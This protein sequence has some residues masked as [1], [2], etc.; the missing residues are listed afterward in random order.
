ME[1]DHADDQTP[2]W[3]G[4]VVLTV[5]VVCGLNRNSPPCRRSVTGGTTAGDRL[6]HHAPLLLLLASSLPHAPAHL[7]LWMSRPP[8]PPEQ[9]LAPPARSL[10]H[11]APLLLLLSS[12]VSS[13]PRALL[14]PSMD[15]Q[16]AVGTGTSRRT[17]RQIG[18]RRARICP[19]SSRRHRASRRPPA[20]CPFP[21]VRHL[22]R[23]G[24]GEGVGRMVVVTS[25]ARRGGAAG[26]PA[27]VPIEAKRWGRCT[28]V[29]DLFSIANHYFT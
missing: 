17:S 19:S 22:Y 13:L 2:S 14:S 29:R 25:G 28:H 3:C 8:P 12:S 7:F 5:L 4:L 20:A 6:P 21:R 9:A 1:G 26:C 11:L 18:R 23:V 27:P 24:E 10:P 16:D 15:E